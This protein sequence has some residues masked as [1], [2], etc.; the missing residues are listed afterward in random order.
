MTAISETLKTMCDKKNPQDRKILLLAELVE[1]KCNILADNQ[2]SLQESLDSTSNKL[3]ELMD[4]IKTHNDCPV[5]KNKGKYEEL[6]FYIKNP[7]TTLVLILGALVLL[8]GFFEQ[9]VAGF[10]KRI[11]GL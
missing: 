9:I 4:M 3:D 2:K 11:F 8:S 5:Y 1:R 10:I 7:K 6:S